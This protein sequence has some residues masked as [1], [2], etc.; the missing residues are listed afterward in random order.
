VTTAVTLAA[1]PWSDP[2]ARALRRAQ[3]TELSARYGDEGTPEPP[4]EQVAVTLVLALDGDPVGCGSLRDLGDVAEHAAGTGEVKR[5]YVVPG[6]R[7]R[8]LARTL[9]R[10]LEAHA[11]DRGW[12]RLVL[13]TG[14]QQPEAIGL[15]LSLGYRPV[16]R[17]GEWVDVPDSR[18]L[19]R[20]LGGVAA[21][22]TPQVGPAQDAG[23]GP[24]LLRV[25]PR[26]PGALDRA[27]SSGYRPVLPFGAWQDDAWGIYLGRV[28]VTDARH[29]DAP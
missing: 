2:V 4:A 28:P 20:D 15:Y 7:G 13:E 6:A 25:D 9:V 18:C 1:V 27:L 3:Q 11:A 8:G 19:A 24:A 10:A 21:P 22:G 29:V 16:P 5:L 26:E 14:L 23:A 17:Y 12:T